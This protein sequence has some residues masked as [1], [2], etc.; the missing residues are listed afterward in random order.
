MKLTGPLN[1]QLNAY[2]MAVSK[3]ELILVFNDE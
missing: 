2:L 3:K 1:T